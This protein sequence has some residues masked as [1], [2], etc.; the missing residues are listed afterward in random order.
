VE[1]FQPSFLPG[2]KAPD[3]FSPGHLF[4]PFSPGKPNYGAAEDPGWAVSTM[5]TEICRALKEA[6][7]FGSVMPERKT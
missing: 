7:A 6:S 1:R 2:E 3:T 5:L 4:T